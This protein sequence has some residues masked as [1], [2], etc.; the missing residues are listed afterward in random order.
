MSDR[1]LIT[2]N[3]A[4]AQLN[5]KLN[6]DLKTL[7][8]RIKWQ[9]STADVIEYDAQQLS[10]SNS[11]SPSPT[12]FS[13]ASFTLDPGR[14][15]I[16]A[17]CTVDNSGPGAGVYSSAL[18][19]G[20]QLIETA[21]ETPLTAVSLLRDFT[22]SSYTWAYHIGLEQTLSLTEP[23]DITFRVYAAT[24]SAVGEAAV[25]QVRMTAAPA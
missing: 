17:Y 13:A 9:S 11:M 19:V 4:F 25:R 18:T 8:S 15:V 5:E 3:R 20:T 7:V 1:D 16:L 14:W 2:P 10:M 12:W 21:D 6:R 22:S 23:T 24:V